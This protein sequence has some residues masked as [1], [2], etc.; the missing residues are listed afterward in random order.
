MQPR[1]SFDTWTP[2]SPSRVN[3]IDAP[4]HPRAIGGDRSIIRGHPG[5]DRGTGIFQQRSRTV[6]Y[7]PTHTA[8]RISTLATLLV[9][10]AIAPTAEAARDPAED[11]PAESSDVL[12]GFHDPEDGQLDLSEYLATATGFLPIPIIITEPAVGYGGGLAALFLHDPFAGVPIEDERSAQARLA[13]GEHPRRKPPNMSFAGGAATENG[14]WFVG[15][16]HRAFWFDDRL[17]YSGGLLYSSVNLDFYGLGGA[18]PPIGFNIEGIAL[19]QELKARVFSTDLFVGLRYVFLDS[20][21]TVDLPGGIP[22]LAPRKLD[23][24][25]SGLGPVLTF[26][27][28]DNVLTPLR[29]VDLDVRALFYDGALGSDFDYQAYDAVIQGF[30]S[31]HPRIVIGAVFDT[32]FSQGRAP[33]YTLPYVRLRG[34]PSLRYQDETAL[35]GEFELRW[36]VLGRW[37]LVG[38]AGVGGTL[39]RNENEGTIVA[40]GAGF[41]YLIARL[42]GLEVGVDV[43]R[44]PED[45]AFYIQVGYA[46][47]GR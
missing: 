28:L 24:T 31:P 29:G 39:P 47:G 11:E 45:T 1:Q 10:I 5:E 41:R 19:G 23:T 18:L 27:T 25:L 34:V 12:A 22:G 17:R 20:T 44:G 14:T 37:S 4:V 32:R 43:A 21:V 16:G 15:G 36:R 13:E 33:F 3:F 35:S 6:E 40:G 8:R 9:S 30:F 46:W 7:G 2:V 26:T 42:L 38:F